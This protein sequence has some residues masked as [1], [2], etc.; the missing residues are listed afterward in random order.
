MSSVFTP[1]PSSTAELVG[2]EVVADRADDPDLGEE[3]RGEG[4]MDGGAAQHA[5][6]LPERSAH[7]VER[8]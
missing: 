2:A 7:R 8:D 1:R 6:A 3:A 5:V 4:E